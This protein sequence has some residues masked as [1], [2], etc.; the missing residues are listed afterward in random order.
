M[1]PVTSGS[2][3]SGISHLDLSVLNR[4][5]SA[6]WYAEVLGFEIRGDRFNEKLA[7]DGSTWCTRAA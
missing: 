5:A 6:E 4:H 2:P 1:T 7:F 3:L